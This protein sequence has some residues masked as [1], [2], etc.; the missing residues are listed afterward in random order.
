[1]V[2]GVWVDAAAAHDSDDVSAGEA[3]AVFEDRRDAERG[4]GFASTVRHGSVAP[5]APRHHPGERPATVPYWEV[6][7]HGRTRNAVRSVRPATVV[8]EALLCFG[9]AGG[10]GSCPWGLEPPCVRGA[11]RQVRTYLPSPVNWSSEGSGD[12]GGQTLWIR[13][14]TAGCVAPLGLLRGTMSYIDMQLARPAGLSAS[15]ESRSKVD[16][17]DFATLTDG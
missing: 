17:R 14:T 1:V 12:R 2:I 10:D 7:Q 3:A 9:L 15:A 16:R 6:S 5:P 11:S 8:T 13:W 4:Q